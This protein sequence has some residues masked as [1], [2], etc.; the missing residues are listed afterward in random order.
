MNRG[1]RRKRRLRNLICITYCSVQLLVV[2]LLFRGMSRILNK[3]IPTDAEVPEVQGE[4]IVLDG[5]NGEG[6]KLDEDKLIVCLD[7][8]HGGKDNGTDYRLR[9]EKNDNLKIADAVADYLTK[10]QVQV[11]MTRTDDTFVSLD[12]RTTFANQHKASYFVS[13][14]RNDG[15]GN[16]VETWICSNAN[17]EAASLAEGIMKGLNAVGIQRNRG[18]KKG[19]QKSESKDYYVTL[20]SKMPA[21]I[22][23]L[24]FMNN[25]TDNQL[26]D[27]NLSSYAKAIGDAIIATYS[28]YNKQNDETGG[29][30][31]KD[32]NEPQESSQQQ[33]ETA[34]TGQ[35]LQN[36]MIDI[37]AL[38]TTS[39][40]WG[41]GRNTDEKNRPVDAV[42]ASEKYAK[43]NAYFIGE[44][45]QDIYLTFDEGYEYGY[46]E[47]ILNTL[48]EKGVKATFFVT[49]PYAKQQPELVRRMIDEGH[50]L[51]NHSV[52]HPA[53]GLPSETVE[54]QQNEVKENHQYIK[55]NF[56]YDMYLFRYPA[57]KFSEQ[58]LAIVNNCNY[59]SVFWSFAYLDYDVNHQ[60]DQRE[61]LTKLKERMHP[62][63][64]YLLH[65]ESETNAAILGE[66]IDSVRAAG[67][68]F[69]TL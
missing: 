67:Y 49:E 37:N 1:K 5:E 16:G 7:A 50:V 26:F 48:K 24:G 39:V 58:S 22:V 54:Q 68:G 64:I 28:Q 21:C 65:A 29:T 63:A 31:A 12:G 57:G 46:S 36:Q 40:G 34:N 38:D 15:D 6:N 30:D 44:E 19:T 41:Q 18:V 66:F 52:T 10:Q 42:A 60:P 3:I 32:Q 35:V 59:K 27:S 4:V 45:S 55:D 61:S 56:G 53:A 14:H 23:E 20:H 17:E 25:A 9:Y 69:K 43:Y 11:I 51:G 62:G 2:L 8:G 33:E 13:L 47:S